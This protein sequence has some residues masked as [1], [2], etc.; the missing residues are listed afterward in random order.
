MSV[1]CYAFHIMQLES[2]PHQIF[3]REPELHTVKVT[4][5]RNVDFHGLLFSC[6]Q[7]FLTKSL[8]IT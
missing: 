5:L 4:P 2:E 3:S 6:V 8:G 1:G 7:W